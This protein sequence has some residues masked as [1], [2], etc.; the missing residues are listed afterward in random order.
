MLDIDCIDTEYSFQG[1]PE[2]FQ[3]WSKE[4]GIY[5][6]DGNQIN[7]DGTLYYCTDYDGP[8]KY[9]RTEEEQ[10]KYIEEYII[11]TKTEYVRS[12]LE[13]RRRDEI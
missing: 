1:T 2:D 12:C 9:F 5:G 13:E 11:D 3:K 7:E 10:K 8:G 6:L 4:Y